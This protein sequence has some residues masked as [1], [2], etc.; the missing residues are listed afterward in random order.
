MPP[1]TLPRAVAVVDPHRADCASRCKDYAGVGVAFKLV[2][3]LEGDADT[4][5]E[6]YG[7][8]VALGTLADVMPLTGENRKLVRIGLRRITEG[9]RPGIKCLAQV[10]GTW[11]KEASATSVA[12]TL[13]PRI[14]AAGRMGSPRGCRPPADGADERR[15]PSLWPRLFIRPISTAK[16]WRRRSSR[17][18]G[19]VSAPVRRCSRIGCWWWKGKTGIPGS[20]ASSLPV[21]WNRRESPA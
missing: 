5:A 3:A 1:D 9:A 15:K 4:V 14:N 20:S 18:S 12:F 13:A 7:D 10:A 21:F 8:L 2:C 6:E 17:R 11:G 19:S 16:P